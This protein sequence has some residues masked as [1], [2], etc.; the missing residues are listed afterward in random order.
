MSNQT[1]QKYTKLK[2]INENGKVGYEYLPTEINKTIDWLMC[3]Y[4]IA[5]NMLGMNVYYWHIR[6]S[7]S[8]NDRKRLDLNFINH[9][10]VEHGNEPEDK[11]EKK[12]FKKA[13]NLYGFE[14]NYFLDEF[15]KRKKTNGK[16]ELTPELNLYVEQWYSIYQEPDRKLMYHGMKL[17]DYMNLLMLFAERE[18]QRSIEYYKENV[19]DTAK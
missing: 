16:Y 1:V 9:V 17:I 19:T 5:R 4:A 3:K 10:V 18:T 8:I 12:H 15:K 14:V 11:L 2:F 6:N 13:W 7:H